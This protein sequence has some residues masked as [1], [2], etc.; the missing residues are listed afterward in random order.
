VSN[1]G[2]A[3]NTSHANNGNAG[4]QGGGGG[5][6]CTTNCGTDPGPDGPGGPGGGGSG[7]LLLA[8]VGIGEEC[9]ETNW[10]KWFRLEMP[11]E[12]RPDNQC[13]WLERY[14]HLQSIQ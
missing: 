3:N 2:N 11:P 10:Y 7:L 1:T 14:R 4:N 13:N 12:K 5:G 8:D 6:G 9:T